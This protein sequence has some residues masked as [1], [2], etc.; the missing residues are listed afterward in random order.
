MKI[1][2]DD[3]QDRQGTRP[4]TIR[5]IA[6]DTRRSVIR[7]AK[8]EGMTISQWVNRVLDEQ[9]N[10]TLNATRSAKGCPSV[11]LHILDELL[12]LHRRM[13]RVERQSAADDGLD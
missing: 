3:H 8:R 10:Q 4:W 11:P 1:G 5:D 9:A 13:E 6:D 12:N 7:A 2:C